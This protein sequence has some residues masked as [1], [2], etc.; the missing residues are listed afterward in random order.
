MQY[1]RTGTGK[2]D[3]YRKFN[4]TT[5][6]REEYNKTIFLKQIF[7]GRGGGGSGVFNCDCSENELLVSNSPDISK[8]AFKPYSFP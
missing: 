8:M 4:C 6:A 5:A 7:R 1:K 2:V 3:P